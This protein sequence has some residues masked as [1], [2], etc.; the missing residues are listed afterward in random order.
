M[1]DDLFASDYY[2][3]KD[4]DWQNKFVW[5]EIK[6]WWWSWDAL[7]YMLALHPSVLLCWLHVH[8]C[9]LWSTA[10]ELST[11]CRKDRQAVN[12]AFSATVTVP[13]PCHYQELTGSQHAQKQYNSRLLGLQTCSLSILPGSRKASLSLSTLFLYNTGCAICTVE[14]ISDTHI[15]A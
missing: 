7:H 14:F 4:I 12:L 8:S 3:N 5:S 15:A 11:K 10:N 9:T 1:S 13:P 2:K 6:G